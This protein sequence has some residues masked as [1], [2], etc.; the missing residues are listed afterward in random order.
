MTVTTSTAPWWYVAALAG[1]FTLLG[2]L[3][4]L[5]A[6]WLIARRKNKLDDLRRFDE[7]IITAYI[8]LDELSDVLHNNAGGDEDKERVTY[9]DVYREVLRIETRI[10]LIAPPEVVRIV[11]H[12]A[13]VVRDMEPTRAPLQDRHVLGMP[14]L[15]DDLH[16]LRRVIRSKLRVGPGP[17]PA[18]TR[19]I[20]V[21]PNRLRYSL[22]EWRFGRD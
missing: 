1:G 15:V 18:L 9:W 5:T 11:S 19:R 22:D 13:A 2:A 14:E 3:V 21:I 17:R 4:S 10:E 8:R 6:A 7:D 16:D 20:A 12:V